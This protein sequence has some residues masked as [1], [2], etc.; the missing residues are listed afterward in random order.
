MESLGLIKDW[1]DRP[2]ATGTHVSV[3]GTPEL[4]LS[5]PNSSGSCYAMVGEPLH[6]IGFLIDNVE[7]ARAWAAEWNR[8]ADLI[9][10]QVADTET[11][12]TP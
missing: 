4:K 5:D 11:G 12:Q 3:F 6:S 7:Q 10:A 1:R 9:D 2:I 8:I